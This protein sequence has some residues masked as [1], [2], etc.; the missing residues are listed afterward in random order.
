MGFLDSA[1]AQAHLT[2]EQRHAAD[3]EEFLARR[4]RLIAEERALRRDAARIKNATPDERAADA[5]VRAVRREEEQSIWS[6]DHDGVPN[7]FPGMEFLSG[8]FA[9]ALVFG[10]EMR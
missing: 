4:A 7:T 6:V 1:G 5:V 9:R 10:G 2:D 3:V 8:E